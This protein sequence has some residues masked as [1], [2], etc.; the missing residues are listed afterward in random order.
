VARTR[1]RRRK[2]GTPRRRGTPPGWTLLVAGLLIGGLV[3]GGVM[4]WRG[5]RQDATP[6]VGEAPARPAR[7]APAAVPATPA[8]KRFEFYEMLPNSEVIVPEEDATAR[9]DKAPA[10]IEVPGI[11]VLQAGSYGSFA[12]ADRVKAQIALLGVKSQIQRIS[13]DEREFHRVRIGPIENLDEL[14]RTRQ[15]LRTAKIDTLLIRVG[16]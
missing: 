5:S 10:P 2:P 6:A 12:E 3:V 4:W 7:K 8:E 16:E 15:R 9:P 11:Y 1:N 13:V 14:N